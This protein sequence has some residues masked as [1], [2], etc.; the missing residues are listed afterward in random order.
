MQAFVGG[1]QSAFAVSVVLCLVAAGFS[2][3]RGKENRRAHMAPAPAG[4]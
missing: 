2:L 1:I 3:V 4:E